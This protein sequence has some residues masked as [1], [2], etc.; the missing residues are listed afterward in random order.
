MDDRS[1]LIEDP[2]YFG[3][4]SS[5]RYHLL[6]KNSCVNHYGEVLTYG[7]SPKLGTRA[8]ISDD[9]S[10]KKNRSSVGF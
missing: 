7:V 1:Q 2:S 5:R 6:Y 4:H 10:R 3:E 9:A 8:R